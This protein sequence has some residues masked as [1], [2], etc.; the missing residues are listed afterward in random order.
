MVVVV[1]AELLRATVL[2][3]HL[4]SINIVVAGNMRIPPHANRL[5]ILVSLSERVH[6]L[7]ATRL[8]MAQARLRV[9]RMNTPL[10]FAPMA[11]TMGNFLY[12]KN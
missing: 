2:V 6:E 1:Q 7:T 8:M 9:T 10:S 12:I 4:I 11:L 3:V 5:T